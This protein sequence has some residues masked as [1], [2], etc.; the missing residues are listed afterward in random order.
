MD[1]LDVLNQRE[2]KLGRHLNRK[3]FITERIQV[4]QKRIPKVKPVQ[5]RAVVRKGEFRQSRI[6]SL[7]VP[8]VRYVLVMQTTALRH[9]LTAEIF[10]KLGKAVVLNKHSTANLQKRKMLTRK[11]KFAAQDKPNCH[12][13]ASRNPK[14][15]DHYLYKI[16]STNP[17]PEKPKNTTRK[18][19][20]FLLE[21]ALKNVRLQE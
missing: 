13:F 6:F 15:A 12:K 1:S 17:L 9:F 16:S 7:R 11:V 20:I 8:S 21:M 14:A 19:G 2:E 4:P 10:S 3:R 18:R 5:E